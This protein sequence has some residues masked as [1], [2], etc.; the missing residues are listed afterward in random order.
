MR[1]VALLVAPL[2]LSLVL[3]VPVPVEAASA[4]F[5]GPIVPP[6]C[7]CEQVDG[8]ATAP[9]YGCVLAVVQNLINFGV[10]LGV[11][12]ATLALVYAGFTWMMSGGNPEARSKGRGMLLN[13]FIGLFILLTAWLL[14]DF[15][16]KQLYSGDNGSKDFGPWNSILASQGND[17][18]IVATTPKKIDGVLGGAL[19]GGIA[20]GDRQTGAAPVSGTK[21]CP[22]C[23]SLAKLNLS[24]KHSSSCTLDPAVASR[25]VKLSNSY[26][27]GWI[28]TEAYPPTTTRHTNP[29]HYNGTCIDA[30]FTSAY[31]V[32]K[33]A[34]FSTAAKQAGLRPV[35]E[36]DDCKLR[37][38][39]RARGVTAFCKSDQYYTH[40]TGTHF[41]LYGN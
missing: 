39:V 29:C 31:T 17:T 16:M 15:I 9:S 2:V 18:C 27:G 30:G 21:G 37:D 4:T 34:A 32:D 22:T 35:F 24:C 23:V 14:V 19:I 12:A 11:I 36:T 8:I 38:S 41:S 10:T 7:N 26:P 6:E 3:L 33:V 25:V 40:I 13:V 28:I 5:F 20:G 1:R